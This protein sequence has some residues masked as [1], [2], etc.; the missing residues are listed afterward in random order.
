MIFEVEREIKKGTKRK[1]ILCIKVER[2]P[3]R[4]QLL[5]RHLSTVLSFYYVSCQESDRPSRGISMYLVHW[6]YTYDEKQ[7][8]GPN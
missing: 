7:A 6:S 5:G 3:E 4:K 1:K 2:L 8:S